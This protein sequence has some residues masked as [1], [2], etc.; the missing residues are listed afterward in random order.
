MGF[1]LLGFETRIADAEIVKHGL[2]KTAG[3]MREVVAMIDARIY[4]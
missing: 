4:L 1:A 3:G 2:N